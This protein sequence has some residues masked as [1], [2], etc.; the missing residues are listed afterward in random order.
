[1]GVNRVGPDTSHP[2]V[3]TNTKIWELHYAFRVQSP[4]V[5]V[6]NMQM[7]DV[8]YGVYHPHFQDHVYRNMKIHNA[9]AEPFNRGHDDDSAQYGT[10]TVDGLE[11]TSKYFGG[12]MPF[13]QISDNNVTGK[14]VS[15]FRNVSVLNRPEKGN[16]PLV[17]LGGGPRP[18]PKTETGVPCFIHDY[19]GP[20]KHAKVMSVKT[21]E[22]TSDGLTYRAEPPLTGDESRVAEVSNVKFPT[23]LTPKD[24]LPPSTVITSVQPRGDKLLV[25]G[26]VSDNGEVTRVVVNG[27]NAKIDGATGDWEI[28]LPRS[29]EI[30]ARGEDATGNVEKL[31]HKIRVS[32]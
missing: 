10:V 14:A 19:Y 17:N 13:I 2:F 24:D 23:L 6:E 26:V 16:K 18:T 28:E 12:D 11:F 15:H 29:A 5:L 30:T 20:G 25:R 9:A 8:V 21:K 1:M 22:L 4:S 7:E 27:Q 31:E 3:L 32:V